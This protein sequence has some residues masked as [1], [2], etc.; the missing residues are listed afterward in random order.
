MKNIINNFN[1][2]SLAGFNTGVNRGYKNFDPRLDMLIRNMLSAQV[3]PSLT[4]KRHLSVS[5]GSAVPE[6][7]GVDKSFKTNKQTIYFEYNP[8]I[9][10]LKDILNNDTKTTKEKQLEI[11]KFML[12]TW[13]NLIDD[14]KADMQNNKPI[15]ESFKLINDYIQDYIEALNDSLEKL[16][17]RRI[18]DEK[19]TIYNFL[20][21]LE[22]RDIAATVLNGILP[23]IS[24]PEGVKYNEFI[25]NLGGT[26][27]RL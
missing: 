25:I 2:N 27:H 13:I 20:Y 19:K 23:I 15:S 17:K 21:D 7:V 1:A 5:T 24:R 4:L 10:N 12:K 11:E 18:N 14:K 26:V 8:I 3:T 16:K 9:A 6:K 22:L